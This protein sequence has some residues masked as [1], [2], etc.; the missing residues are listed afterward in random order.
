MLI[1]GGIF[2]GLDAF[3]IFKDLA[4]FAGAINATTEADLDK[5]GEH[6]ASAVAKIGVDALMSLLTKKVTDEI[7]KG[8]DN[9]NQV[10]EVHAHSD[11][12]NP[13]LPEGA[14]GNTDQPRLPEGADSNTS[15]PRLESEGTSNADT[16]VSRSETD[17]VQRV[18]TDV[19]N[20]N[21]DYVDLKKQYTSEEQLGE[22][23]II[24][25]RP[26]E[27]RA[28]PRLVQEYGGGLGDWVKKTSS[29][30]NAPDGTHIETHWY[31]NLKT[32]Q[33]VEPKTI[34]NP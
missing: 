29:S 10:D 9:V 26:D 23:G 31:E 3:T 30:V 14:G 19:L 33:K 1:A 5:A 15:Q 32:G 34:I 25:V 2:F 16:N 27:L 28:A 7:G 24:I 4:G 12:A 21:Q 20:E 22:S 13:R 18:L 8:I 17:G 11:G 6:L